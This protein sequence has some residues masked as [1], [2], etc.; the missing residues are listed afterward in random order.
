M[1]EQGAEAYAAGKG[2]II[3]LTHALAASLSAYGIQVNCISPGWIETQNYEKLSEEEHLQHFSQ[4]VGKPNDIAAAC[5]FLS[6]PE[7][8]FINGTNLVIG[9]GMT[10]KM[11]YI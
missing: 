11:I 8:N 6:A 5:I 9:G 1:S 3:A 7:N 4:R 2:G 10:K